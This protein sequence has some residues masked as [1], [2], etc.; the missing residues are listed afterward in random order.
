MLNASL[1]GRCRHWFRLWLAVLAITATLAAPCYA[2]KPMTLEEVEAVIHSMQKAHASL[3]DYVTIFHEKIIVD[4]GESSTQK[5]LLKFQKPFSVYLRWLDGD[6][7]GREVI[8]IKGAY[9]G[10]MWVHNGSFPDITL[11]LSPEICQALSNGR[12]PVTEAGVGFIVDTIANDLAQSKDRPQD[13]VRCVDHG[14]RVVLGEV[15]RCL[16]LIS[17]PRE[18]S[19]FYGHRAFLCQSQR[20]GLLNKITVWDHQNKMVEDYGFENTMVNVGLT[21]KDFDPEN[22][23]YKF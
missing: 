6:S 8:Y 14:Q 20:T 11:C 5:V 23:D 22:P 12:H 21:A 15:S 2:Q 16:E 9:D 7:L 4:D 17:P 19:S 3:A 1:M 10:K 13:K 18:D